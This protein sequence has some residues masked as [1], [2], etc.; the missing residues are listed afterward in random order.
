ML[1][2]YVRHKYS[3]TN[4]IGIIF[5]SDIANTIKLEV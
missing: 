3:R 2:I 1:D 4:L 5:F